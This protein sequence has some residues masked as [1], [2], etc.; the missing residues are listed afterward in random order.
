[1][2]SEADISQSNQHY[3][4]ET[5]Y[6]PR[7]QKSAII[8]ASEVKRPPRS[9]RRLP[10]LWIANVWQPLLDDIQHVK[11]SDSIIS[12]T[13]LQLV[14]SP[15]R[16]SMPM[17]QLSLVIQAILCSTGLRKYKICE[18]FWTFKSMIQ[19]LICSSAEFGSVNY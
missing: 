12:S 19:N 3:P 17:T 5:I 14:L 7:L 6:N 18:K 15:N 16:M 2:A 1:M 4:T 8:V 10:F 11:A 13:A 9:Y